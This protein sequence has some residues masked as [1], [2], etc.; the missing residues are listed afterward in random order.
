M[1]A[2]PALDENGGRGPDWHPHS[3]RT[4]T[5]PRP[6]GQNRQPPFG[7][8][9]FMRLADILEEPAQYLGILLGLVGNNQWAGRWTCCAGIR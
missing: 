6:S 1:T 9:G 3:V 4:I 8:G 7:S 5:K 2:P